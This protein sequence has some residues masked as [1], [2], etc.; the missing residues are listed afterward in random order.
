MAVALAVQKTAFWQQGTATV[1]WSYLAAA[2]IAAARQVADRA[3]ARPLF[4]FS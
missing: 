2:A 3:A 1:Q 4:L